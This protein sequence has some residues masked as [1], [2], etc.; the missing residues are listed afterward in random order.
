M[1]SPFFTAIYEE[2]I[3]SL[4]ELAS[5]GGGELL[6]ALDPVS[7]SGPPLNFAC[8]HGKQMSANTLLSVGADCTMDDKVGRNALLC[9]V[10][11]RWTMLSP[12]RLLY[13]LF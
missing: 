3:E 12:L 1:F 13:I 7:A 10:E 5:K 6:G 4:L 8:M 9:A 11:V 2:N